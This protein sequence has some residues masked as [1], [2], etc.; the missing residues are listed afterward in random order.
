MAI[1]LD[2]L[3]LSSTNTA[4]KTIARIQEDALKAAQELAAPTNTAAAMLKEMTSFGV[5]RAELLRFQKELDAYKTLQEQIAKPQ[6]LAEIEKMRAEDERL[7]ELAL[8]SSVERELKRMRD[9]LYPPT[10]LLRSEV[11]T[12]SRAMHDVATYA[13]D[14]QELFNTALTPSRREMIECE[15]PRLVD[16]PPNPIHKTNEKLEQVENQIAATNSA[17]ATLGKLVTSLGTLGAEARTDNARAS[18]LALLVACVS[19][20]VAVTAATLTGVQTWVQFAD[21]QSRTRA[22]LKLEQIQAAQKDAERT[23]AVLK[24]DNAGLRD[25][26]QKIRN[27]PSGAP[28][29]QQQRT[30]GAASA[31]FEY[32]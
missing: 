30:D 13:R 17:L 4:A 14:S 12:V 16:F 25:E 21:N 29:L 31:T 24:T 5:A 15:F 27:Q 6:W 22:E 32:Y 28:P 3:E 23:I 20:F 18:K 11:D 8:G 26:L 19:V 2:A 1:D 9:F 10:S 7:K